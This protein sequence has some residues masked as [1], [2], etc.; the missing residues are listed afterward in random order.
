MITGLSIPLSLK[1]YIAFCY[2]MIIILF[3]AVFVYH[4]VLV[5][6]ICKG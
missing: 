3:I 5:G 2:C 1:G 6:L 4:L